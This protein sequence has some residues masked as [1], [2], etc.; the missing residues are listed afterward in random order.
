MAVS[1]GVDS[2]CLLD[3]LSKRP[4]IELI[5]AH[6]DHGIRPD[7]SEDRKFVETL[8]KNL[9]HEFYYEEGK[10]GPGASEALAREKRYEFLGRVKSQTKSRAIITAHH[11]DDLIETTIINLLR[12]TN[13]RGLASLRSTNELIRP[14]LSEPKQ[15][16]LKYAKKY[17][18]TWREDPSNSDEK[19]LRNFVR[20]QIIPK[21][22]IGQRNEL[23]GIIGKAGKSNSIIDSIISHEF[24]QELSAG[25]LR[26]RWFIGLPHAIAKEVAVVWLSQN[27][28]Q[29]DKRLIEQIVVAG[30][31]FRP[32]KLLSI[33]LK[34]N[35]M[36]N[37]D[38]LALVLRE[39]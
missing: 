36:V 15:E 32:G 33:N 12:G 11:Q 24:A 39:R 31:T 20:Q 17:K 30:K 19:Y 29:Y 27:K 18:L 5:V 10:L 23:L 38:T 8:A 37:K 26:R 2:V 16:I 34:Y 28:L 3:M 35:L 4:G 22:S 9:G 1:G 25:E 7:S 21:L 6:F 13:R 14:L